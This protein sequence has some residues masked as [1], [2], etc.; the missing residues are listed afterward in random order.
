MR[1]LVSKAAPKKIIRY[2]TIQPAT[3]DLMTSALTVRQPQA[4]IPKSLSAAM[5]AG[6]LESPHGQ[7]KVKLSQTQ[8]N[9]IKP[10]HPEKISNHCDV[11]RMNPLRGVR[12]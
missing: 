5:R 3:M 11:N 8:S 9:S 10:N 1:S 7:T 6:A 4:G 2:R 12:L